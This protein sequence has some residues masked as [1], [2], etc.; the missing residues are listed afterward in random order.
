MFR[1]S[2]FLLQFIWFSDIVYRF[3]WRKC[4]CTEKISHG[5]NY[6]LSICHVGRFCTY[7]V[8]L[9]RHI[10]SFPP[11]C[12]YF[13]AILN[14]VSSHLHR[15][16]DS[17]PLHS[18]FFSLKKLSSL[19]CEKRREITCDDW[20]ELIFSNRSSF[21]IERSSEM[22]SAFSKCSSRAEAVIRS[23]CMKHHFLLQIART[24]E[25]FLYLFG[26]AM[27]V[28]IWAIFGDVSWMKIF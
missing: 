2:F 1:L 20:P 13:C 17:G 26:E 21:T 27:A 14:V 18:I 4:W 22:T 8:S 6:L 12:S 3:F 28:Q 5:N 23:V 15:D 16:F 11:L 10:E 24:Y 25:R 7:L 9:L 19:W